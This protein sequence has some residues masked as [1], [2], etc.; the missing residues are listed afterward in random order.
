MGD[1]RSDL[2]PPYRVLEA[3]QCC[4][5]H[6]N[7]WVWL[8]A[9]WLLGQAGSVWWLNTPSSSRTFLVCGVRVWS[10]QEQCL[11]DILCFLCPRAYHLRGWREGLC[12]VLPWVTPLSH[13]DWEF[14]G[15]ALCTGHPSWPQ[16]WESHEHPCCHINVPVDLEGNSELECLSS[17]C[18][19]QISKKWIHKP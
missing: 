13:A 14:P 9:G 1:I 7:S 2:C 18:K 5:S 19:L 8:G 12:F 15:T 4:R 11:V 6:G 10:V 3:S 16:S 17:V